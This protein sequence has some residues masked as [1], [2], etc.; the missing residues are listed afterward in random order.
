MSFIG[1]KK[2]LIS[3]SSG[4]ILRAISKVLTSG[5]GFVT[6]QTGETYALDS[7]GDNFYPVQP[8]HC[9]NMNGVDNYI[10]TPHLTGTETAIN[11]GTAIASISAGRI[12]F[13]VGTVWNLLLSDGTFYKCDE[14]S[15]IMIADSSGAGDHGTLMNTT[16]PGGR[17]TQNEYSFQN[18]VGYSGALSSDGVDD[19]VRV[20]DQT[21]IQN[22]FDGGGEIEIWINP[23]SAGGGGF[24]RI[25][26]KGSNTFVDESWSAWVEDVSGSTARFAFRHRFTSDFDLPRWTTD[27]RVINL[28]QWQKINIIYN[29]NLTSNSPTIKIDDGSS[30]AITL[31]GTLS[32][33]RDSD[34][35]DN[36]YF[37][38][39]GD[40]NR[41]FDGEITQ[42]KMW[43]DITRTNLVA[44]WNLNEM[45]G[46]QALDSSPNNNHGTIDGASW[47]AIPR[48]ESDTTNDI[49]GKALDYVGR[50]K[51]NAKLVESNAGTFDGV[52]DEILIGNPAE[53]Q[54]TSDLTI[55]AFIKNSAASS[56][57]IYMKG[58]DSTNR[59][60]FRLDS[61]GKLIF[62]NNTFAAQGVS[63]TAVNT[64]EW[65]HV[66]VRYTSSTKLV[67]YFVNGV[68]DGSYNETTAFSGSGDASI[69]LFSY[70]SAA[71]F[72]G[73]IFDV[74]I[75]DTAIT[76][77]QINQ[78]YN[79]SLDIGVDPVGWYPLAEGAGE[80]VYDVSGNDNH[81]TITN[82][83]LA[84][85]FWGTKQDEVHYNIQ[86]GFEYYDDDATHLIINRVPYKTDGTKITPVISGYT[87]ISDNDASTF[88]HNNA[89]TKLSYPLAPET[90][91]ADV[92]DGADTLYNAGKTAANPIG[93]TDIAENMGNA[94]GIITATVGTSTKSNLTIKR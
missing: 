90:I 84:N 16:L 74:R 49:A 44:Q 32:G 7:V 5:F 57:I 86:K 30:E 81:G 36:L 59:Q 47:H 18:E 40:T 55:S 54:L 28:N 53:L 35:G 6:S 1:I 3:L 4:R 14:I 58:V 89:E 48:D 60:V 19:Y 63:S 69:G 52:D 64:G 9:L 11:A 50:V 71:P 10:S 24:G 17:T 37:G 61:S 94:T 15:G 34:I 67:E 82:A 75:F 77:T 79:K 51:Y 66:A 38:D 65:V 21:A 43:D 83:T 33:V 88:A 41:V 8:G 46:T 31:T 70:I 93:Y 20:K 12:D 27:N 91:K 22:I 73:Q 25:F 45:S 2:T 39:W 80:T 92:E 56:Q 87:K 62:A 26:Y 23:K 42:V 78:I 76:P 29:S 72:D 13:T 85:T 68:A